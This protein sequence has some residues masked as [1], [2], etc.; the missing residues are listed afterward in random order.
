MCGIFGYIG[1]RKN[2]PNLVIEGLKKLEYRGYDSW[3][4]AAAID[5]KIE[6]FK[7]IGK[8]SDVDEKSFPIK[9]SSLA[10]GHSRW[11]THGGVT[12]FNAHPHLSNSGDV[13]VVHNG[14]IEN[15]EEL[16]DDLKEKGFIFHSE[17]DT[18]VIPNLIEYF[19]K[20]CTLQEALYKT[21][22]ELEGRYAICV[23]HKSQNTLI[24]ARYGSP[25]IL[26]V[27]EGEFFL[28]SD[29]P[30]FLRYTR[31]VNYLDDGQMV[32][33]EDGEK[34]FYNIDLKKIIEKR[35]IAITWSEQS[36]E[37]GDYDHFMIKEIMEQKDTIER[38]INQDEKELGVITKAIMGAYG[39]YFVGCG[40]TG[41]VALT[42]SYMFS[43]IAKRHVNFA[44]G[45][46]YTHISNFIKEK[47]V[48]VAVSQSGETADTLE[49]VAVAKAKKARVISIINVEGST[50]ARESDN[51]LYI[52][53]GPEKSVASTKATTAQLA[54]L[55]LLAYSCAGRLIEGKKLLIETSGR[56]N[57]ML[58]PRYEDYV[59][60]VAKKLDKHDSVYIIGKGVNYPMALEAA[61]KLMEV[62]YI[63]AQGFAAGELKHGPLAL[64]EKG[65]PLIALVANDETKKDVLSNIMEVKARGGFIVGVSPENHSVFDMWI[66]VPDVK[67]AS[68]IVNIIPI[69][70]LAYHLAL[71]RDNDPDK[72]R[73]LAKSVTVK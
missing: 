10:I 65:T 19:L 25:L 43:D 66:K 61:I 52:K 73:N 72:P 46:E 34:T 67:D 37:K 56:I 31:Q 49:A 39:T 68:P 63:H 15:F 60:Q 54:V 29:I 69:Q 40:T 44:F 11:A 48:V 26:G 38:A 30:A 23:I 24:A 50:M 17:T 58:N 1:S 45:S 8:I 7:D 71:L 62:S 13:A 64:I 5:E 47:S 27:G 35:N 55:L 59:R 16:R 57:D 42:A 3:G 53:T 70:M 51:V 32:V 18:E 41:K 9:N 28:A 14:I 20:D 22:E 33:L 36:A 6:L 12:K 21:I 2:A 4:V